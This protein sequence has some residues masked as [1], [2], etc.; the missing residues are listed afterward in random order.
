MK[1]AAMPRSAPRPT[2]PYALAP[3]LFLFLLYTGVVIAVVIDPVASIADLEQWGFGISVLVALFCYCHGGVLLGWR[4]TARL[5]CIVCGLAW[6]FEQT[7]VW[8]GFPFGLYHY[9]DALGPKLWRVPWIVPFNYFMIL[10]PASILTNLIVG[11]RVLEPSRGIGQAL[12]LSLVG[13]LLI[14]GWDMVA[15]PAAATNHQRWIWPMAHANPYFGIPYS[16][17]FGWMFSSTLILLASRR[18]QARAAARPDPTPAWFV[19]LLPAHWLMQWL[20]FGRAA[21]P[22]VLLVGLFSMGLPAIIACNR[23]LFLPRPGVALAGEPEAS[24]ENSV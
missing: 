17:Y 12:R 24:R 2:T 22:G 18:S 3:A 15:D 9:T 19:A 23:L 4:D 11:D 7:S 10:Y 21:P 14:V 16:N 20:T 8:T 6:V 5:F 1:R 13:G